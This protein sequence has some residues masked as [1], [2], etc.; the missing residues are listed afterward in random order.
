VLPQDREELAAAV[1][2]KEEPEEVT[3][4]LKLDRKHPRTQGRPAEA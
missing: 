3:E 1:E 2:K 4:S